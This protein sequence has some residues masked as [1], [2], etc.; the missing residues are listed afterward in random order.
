MTPAFLMF[1][2]R[3]QKRFKNTLSPLLL[4]WHLPQKLQLPLNFSPTFS[5]SSFPN[6]PLGCCPRGL[7]PE[8][9]PLLPVLTSP[10]SPARL[11]WESP[12]FPQ[13]PEKCHPLSCGLSEGNSRDKRQLRS[14]MNRGSH[15]SSSSIDPRSRCYAFTMRRA[16]E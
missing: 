7:A 2:S 11:P 15:T 1:G 13:T 6:T 4:S 9:F 10:S 3:V 16:L 14:L 12:A 5:T 8:P